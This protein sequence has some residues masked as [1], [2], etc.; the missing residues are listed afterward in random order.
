MVKNLN[1]EGTAR[2][3]PTHVVLTPDHSNWPAAWIP[4]ADP[5]AKVYASGNL[6]ALTA[7]A[8]AIVGTRK[9]SARGLA[10]ARTLG[11]DLSRLGWTIVSG[12]ALGI[13]AA[14]HQGALDSGGR[15]IGVMATGIDRI[16]PR[17]HGNLRHQIEVEGCCITE[18]DPGSSPR[19]YHFPRRNR[20]IAS[21]CQAV[22]VVEAPLKSGAMLTA[23]RA[24]DYDREVFAVP[25]PIDLLTSKGCHHLLRQG[26]HV[27][28]G[29]DDVIQVLGQPIGAKLVREPA[30]EPV[31]GTGL[32]MAGSAARWIYDR[33]NLEGVR[34]D[35]L[36]S[37][38]MGNEGAWTEGLLALE[39]AGLILWLPGSRISRRFW[40]S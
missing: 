23:Y 26:A 27:L 6:K 40:H 13:D 4:M 2:Q 31:S 22:I 37:L 21:L 5:P 15:T 20:L 19:K 11:A 25:G 8:I 33:L 28:E 35:D 38:W 32:P 29:A 24:L 36:R 17:A 30:I 12:L 18:Y 34:R 39:L 14:A 3:C 1:F 10:V 9:A 16:Y 7:S